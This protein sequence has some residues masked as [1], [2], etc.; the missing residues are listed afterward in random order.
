M[1]ERKCQKKKGC[2]VG[3]ITGKSP[4]P[5]LCS[6]SLGV[7]FLGAPTPWVPLPLSGAR[8]PWVFLPLWCSA[9]A[10]PNAR[11]ERRKMHLLLDFGVFYSG[12][13]GRIAVV[14]LLPFGCSY[15]LVF[16]PLGCSYPLVAPTPWCSYPLVFLPHGCS[17]PLRARAPPVPCPCSSMCPCL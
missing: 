2:Q 10:R 5:L 13:R 17:Y 9:C 3:P 15:P 7:L 8:T 11:Q 4:V 1:N 14:G 16:L 6:C 12:R